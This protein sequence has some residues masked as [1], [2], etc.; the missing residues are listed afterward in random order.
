MLVAEAVAEAL[1]CSVCSG[2]V[3]A[4]SLEAALCALLTPLPVPQAFSQAPVV[5]GSGSTHAMPPATV[6]S[7]PPVAMGCGSSGKG[8]HDCCSR[9]STGSACSGAGSGS[10]C[11]DNSG[12]AITDHGTLLLHRACVWSS[13]AFFRR[14]GTASAELAISGRLSS[15]TRHSRGPS[16]A[17]GASGVPQ[18]QARGQAQRQAPEAV[19]EAGHCSPAPTTPAQQQGLA[20]AV[21]QQQPLPEPNQQPP[22]LSTSLSPIPAGLP[23]N[24]PRQGLAA[25]NPTPMLPTM[26]TTTPAGLSSTGS[27]N[28]A[29]HPKGTG[30]GG[31]STALNPLLPPMLMLPARLLALARDTSDR[32]LMRSVRLALQRITFASIGLIE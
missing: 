22:Q 2:E 15:V 23:S 32:Q 6:A 29:P 28:E 5:P 11:A 9:G 30:L 7:T 24:R 14:Y 16:L 21:E 19:L 25:L 31:M 8:G 12:P 10:G 13:A 1:L 4:R 17:G 3:A 18:Q 27:H 20:P 26:V